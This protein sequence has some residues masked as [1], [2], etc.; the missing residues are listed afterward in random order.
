MFVVNRI[1]FNQKRSLKR[2]NDEYG[3]KR[4]GELQVCSVPCYSRE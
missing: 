3:L 4:I 1:G 2:S